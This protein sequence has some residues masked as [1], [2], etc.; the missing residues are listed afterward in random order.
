MKSRFMAL[1]AAL[2]A[3]PASLFAGSADMPA[4][5][6]AWPRKST[7]TAPKTGPLVAGTGAQSSAH[8]RSIIVQ[9]PA[10]SVA[11]AEPLGSKAMNTAQTRSIIIVGGKPAAQPVAR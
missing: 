2:L 10:G 9:K 3:L 6:A 8:A 5:S 4:Q 1:G 11:K 7:A